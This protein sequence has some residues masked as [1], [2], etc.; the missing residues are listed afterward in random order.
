MLVSEDLIFILPAYPVEGVKDP[1]GAG[2]SFAGGMMG[3][4]A[5]AGEATDRALKKALAYGTMCASFNV[6]DFSL[7]RFQQISRQDIDARL[8]DYLDMMRVE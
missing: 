5:E 3:Y 6:E 8:S 7:K 4:L 1:T 2:D